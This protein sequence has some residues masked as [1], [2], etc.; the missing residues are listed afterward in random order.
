MSAFSPCRSA[1]PERIGVGVG[2][3]IGIELL[4]TD[5]D[6]DTDPDEFFFG[7][8]LHSWLQ[9]PIIAAIV[10]HYQIQ[11][12]RSHQYENQLPNWKPA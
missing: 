1:V 7:F 10:A 8:I 6:S 2:I 5:T 12:L 9:P 11:R 3:G 4:K